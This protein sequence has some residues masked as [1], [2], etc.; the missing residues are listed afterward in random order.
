[1][2]TFIFLRIWRWVTRVERERY[3]FALTAE[4]QA[5][6]SSASE[7][8]IECFSYSEDNREILLNAYCS[9]FCDKVKYGLWWFQMVGTLRQP[10]FMM[11]GC[12]NF[13][14][15]CNNVTCPYKLACEHSVLHPELNCPTCPKNGEFITEVFLCNVLSEILLVL[16][17]HSQAKAT[18]VCRLWNQVL[19]SSWAPRDVCVT[20]DFRAISRKPPGPNETE[21]YHIGYMLDHS[22]TPSTKALSLV[23]LGYRGCA[24]T[25]MYTVY[26]LF[27]LKSFKL[28]YILIKDFSACSE[29]FPTETGHR[30][31][32]LPVLMPVCRQLLVVNCTF[33]N[34]VGCFHHA[35]RD[36]RLIT[37]D[38]L[39]SRKL[40]V[41]VPRMSFDC[42]ANAGEIL[43]CFM[44]I[45]E[46][47][48]PPADSIKERVKQQHQLMVET[49]PYP[50][51]WHKFRKLLKRHHF[52]QFVEKDNDAFWDSLD[53][54]RFDDLPLSRYVLHLINARHDLPLEA[55]H[56]F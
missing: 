41:T 6:L 5:R 48:L 18:R 49:V 13:P 53:L 27:Y 8:L 35:Q 55:V 25:D 40:D 43:R 16:D 33:I 30:L 42:S 51:G 47:S 39:L 24:F 32:R 46:N 31:F 21:G 2:L 1:M 20:V 52:T 19:A 9:G 12:R 11:C 45:L 28:P 10:K 50:D 3:P 44:D 26:S 22:I 4:S 23:N 29:L 38:A 14:T 15:E 7:K 34:A 37:N 54:R 36:E 56:P 17:V